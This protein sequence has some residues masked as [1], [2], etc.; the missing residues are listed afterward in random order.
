MSTMLSSEAYEIIERI[1]ADSKKTGK[2]AIVNQHIGDPMFL[3]VVRYANDPAIVFGVATKKLSGIAA[4]GQQGNPDF[5][6]S[7]WGLLDGLAGR[8]LTGH[9]AIDAISA[10]LA[11]LNPSSA[12]LLRRILLKDLRAGFSE[13]TVNRARPGT[14]QEYPY[15]RCSLPAKSNMAK[16]NWA[17]GMVSQ[18]KA[19]GAFANVDHIAGGVV[20][21]TTRQGT[22]YPEGCMPQLEAA[23]LERLA[24]GMQT[25]GELVVYQDGQLLPRA[26]GNG[27]L[28][29]L[30][31]GGALELGQVVRF[32]C[33]DQ[34]PASAVQP[35]GRYEVAFK[36]RLRGLMEQLRSSQD[37]EHADLMV[38]TPTKIVFS[39]AE[40]FEHYR[41][42][43]KAGKE[44]TILKHPDMIWR[45]G[46]SKD[47]VKLKLEVDVDLVIKAVVPG[48]AGKK[49]E[50]RAGSLTCES[51]C[52][53]LR[54]DVTI[55]NE[56]LRARVDQNPGDFIE[57]ILAVRAN[58]IMAP[59]KSSALYSLFLP[60][61]VEADYR[62]DKTIG[63][64]L[65]SIKD[66]FE[67]A[68]EAV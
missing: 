58:S 35:N 46:D 22:A 68:V 15:M 14:I 42:I 24:E 28:R 23:I 49:T 50:G 17:D 38:L 9:A 19:D 21:I 26:E 43:L 11:R 36:Q 16:W 48:K 54:V 41:E 20:R 57:R 33:W 29:S 12:S 10:E 62:D 25:H 39:K 63:D 64:D 47:S 4:A 52:G 32:Q 31:Q 37:C 27:V 2:Q 8:Q 44:G 59:S 3:A 67:A 61:M 7:T 40:A 65:Q 18:E 51:K 13:G 34:I 60:R 1:A 30:A 5:D 53:L 55:K 66:Q 56:K 6:A 45:D